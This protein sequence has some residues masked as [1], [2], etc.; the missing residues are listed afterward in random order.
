MPHTFFGAC[1]LQEVKRELA[2]MQASRDTEPVTAESAAW[3]Y[4]QAKHEKQRKALHDAKEAALPVPDFEAAFDALPAVQLLPDD[5]SDS[6]SV[7]ERAE[8]LLEVVLPQE[9]SQEHFAPADAQQHAQQ[10]QAKKQQGKQAGAAAGAA[11]VNYN[12][13][14]KRAY[15]GAWKQQL[16]ALEQN[17]QL[18]EDK[19]LGEVRSSICW[20]HPSQSAAASTP[21]ANFVRCCA[22]EEPITCA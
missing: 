8:R 21:T 13:A 3:L 18:I 7:Q 6:G 10:Q 19:D 2:R 11:V 5:F 22:D 16:D 9:P 20:S 14:V 12:Q 15:E 17:L 1:F 4:D